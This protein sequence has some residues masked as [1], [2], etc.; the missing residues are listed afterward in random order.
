[1]TVEADDAVRSSSVRLTSVLAALVLGFGLAIA[2]GDDHDGSDH[3]DGIGND[4][5]H[6]DDC[7]TGECY[8]GPGGGYCTTE[9]DHEGSVDEC[10]E[11]TVCK[12][13]QGG[14]RRCLLI[15]GSTSACDGHDDCEAEHCPDGSSCVNVSNTD[16]LGCEPDPG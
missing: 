3:P 5:E 1:M 6:D 8:L 11:D 10:P 15:C 12:P 13:I 7:E 2:C 9:C 16:H 14:A 4:C